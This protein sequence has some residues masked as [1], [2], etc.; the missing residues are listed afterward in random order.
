MGQV[1]IGLDYLGHGTLS[2]PSQFE[3]GCFFIYW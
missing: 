2:N 1:E 3:E